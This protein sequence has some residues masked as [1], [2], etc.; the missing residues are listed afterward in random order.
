MKKLIIVVLCMCMFLLIA[1]EKRVIKLFENGVRDFTYTNSFWLVSPFVFTELL[2]AY[3]V[4]T[5]YLQKSTSQ[6]KIINALITQTNLDL[7]L[8]SYTEMQNKQLNTEL[9]SK[10]LQLV[11]WTSGS[12]VVGI[13][14]T[15]LIYNI[16]GNHIK[17]I[18]KE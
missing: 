10:K 16:A 9:Q 13:G 12:L 2:A 3:S 8:I 18:N 5:N 1:E 4:Q 15:A 11:L 7:K 17:S 6:D 14:L